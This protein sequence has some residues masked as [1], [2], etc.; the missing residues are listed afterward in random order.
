M[1]KDCTFKPS[2]VAGKPPLEKRTLKDR[3]EYLYQRAMKSKLLAKNRKDKHP[4]EIEAERD[5]A[6]CTFEPK[7]NHNTDF[8]K[9][10][11]NSQASFN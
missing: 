8:S 4:F 3:G 1:S 6:E 7:K 10:L 5:K 9:I 2:L 11:Y